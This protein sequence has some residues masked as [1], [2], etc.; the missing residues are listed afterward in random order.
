MIVFQQGGYPLLVEKRPFKHR[1]PGC[2]PAA[3]ETT[4]A[5]ISA[6]SQIILNEQPYGRAINIGSGPAIEVAVEFKPSLVKFGQESFTIDNNRRTEVRYSRSFNTMPLASVVA[7]NETASLPRLPTFI[8]LDIDERITYSEGELIIRYADISGQ[9]SET[10]QIFRY[11]NDESR[12]G[13]QKYVII[14]AD[15]TS[16]P[17]FASQAKS[18][19]NSKLTNGA[20]KIFSK[21]KIH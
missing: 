1:I 2:N 20:T 11:F 12:Q 9:V 21:T 4:F 7:P 16:V 5:N 18:E 17:L 19:K 3:V 13:D 14:F 6:R 10:R 8:V 15:I